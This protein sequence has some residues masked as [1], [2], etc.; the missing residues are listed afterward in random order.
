MYKNMPN[1]NIKN[2]KITPA[3]ESIEPEM[4]E[5][6]FVKDRYIGEEE[7]AVLHGAKKLGL[8]IFEMVKVILISL[9][10]ILPIRYF[11]VQPFIV[12]G[13]SMEPN[14]H[15]HEYL[16][17]NEIEYRLS[18]PERG[19][20]AILKDPRDSK[21]YLIKRIIGLPGETIE[22][23]NGRVYIDD[24][25]LNETYIADFG[26]ESFDP[27][28]LGDQEYYVLGDNRTNSFDSRRFGPVTRDSLIGKV[29]VRG[30]PLNKLNTFNLP[31][32]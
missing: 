16:I 14:F 10:I 12:Q 8:F 25:E 20:V 13:A 18:Q 7:N 32:Y 5:D 29:W 15:D 24:K 1:K 31:E 17:I 11:L 6:E 19:E 9:A 22:I 30:W 3:E 23:K 21:T 28:K 27:V 26:P 2:Q 4:M